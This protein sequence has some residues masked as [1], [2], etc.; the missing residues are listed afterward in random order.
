M[1]VVVEEAE[2]M[3]AFAQTIPTVIL[4]MLQD[5]ARVLRVLIDT[6]SGSNHK[7]LG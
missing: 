3:P 5:L 7:W 1:V 6:L 4:S 2:G